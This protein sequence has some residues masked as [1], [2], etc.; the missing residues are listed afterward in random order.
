MSQ[1]SLTIRG[2]LFC[3]LI[4]SARWLTFAGAFAAFA[5]AGINKGLIRSALSICLALPTAAFLMETEQAMLLALSAGE[6]ALLTAKE[7]FLGFLL[8]MLASI[9]IWVADLSGGA[10]AGIRQEPGGEDKIG[11]TSFGQTFVIIALSILIFD[12]GFKSILLAVY[13]SYEIWPASSPMPEFNEGA[14]RGFA[15]ILGVA[16]SVAVVTAAPFVLVWLVIDIWIGVAARTAKKFDLSQQSDLLKALLTMG[17]LVVLVG[18]IHRALTDVFMDLGN[19][20][21]LL[22]LFLEA[23]S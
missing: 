19:I 20:S 21:Q 13:K 15:Q 23:S 6:F 11:G 17:M 12:G 8:G 3:L 14:A 1:L 18:P 2:P 7:A 16:F 9:P 4:A 22:G 5:W 10:L